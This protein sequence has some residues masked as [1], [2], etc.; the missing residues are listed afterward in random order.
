MLTGRVPLDISPAKSA[1]GH[2]DIP[3]FIRLV[4]SGQLRPTL[5]P[6][7]PHPHAAEFATVC[8]AEQPAGRPSA[9]ALLLT[10]FLQ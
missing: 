5:P 9:E 1:D 4:T 2:L 3:R 6:E 7:L 10:S 8:T